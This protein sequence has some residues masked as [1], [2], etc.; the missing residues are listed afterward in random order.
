[1][2]TKIIENAQFLVLAC[3]IVAQCVVGE[4]FFLG[5]A[6]YLVANTISVIRC[7]LLKRAAAD[8][9]KDVACTAITAGLIL[10]KILS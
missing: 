6:I 5:Q 7:F 9:I 4:N 2:K 8:K 1:M 10:L 3:L